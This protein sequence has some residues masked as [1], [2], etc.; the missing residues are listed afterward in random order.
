MNSAEA[1]ADLDVSEDALLLKMGIPSALR[2]MGE[3]T[4]GAATPHSTTSVHSDARYIRLCE[5]A[6]TG[7]FKRW[8]GSNG[9]DRRSQLMTPQL[10][11]QHGHRHDENEAYVQWLT[12]T[13]PWLSSVSF[14]LQGALAG[15][16]AS[17]VYMSVSAKS[18]GDFIAHYARVANETRRLLYV[19][20]TFAL[21]GALD[22]FYN[23]KFP[24]KVITT[25]RRQN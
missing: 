10:A 24:F 23:A 9:G 3:D 19:L 14:W 1:N 2:T 16:A 18:D 21:I 8:K 25:C 11:S 22:K 7:Q 20:C 5:S 6:A 17:T 12:F 15:F 4:G 13:L